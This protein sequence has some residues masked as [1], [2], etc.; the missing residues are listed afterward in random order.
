MSRLLASV[1]SAG[2]RT[3]A[4]TVSGS[5]AISTPNAAASVV[6]LLRSISAS[7]VERRETAAVAKTGWTL[8]SVDKE[9]PFRLD[10]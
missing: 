9:L 10:P 8:K 1:T 7:I 2:K 4:N 5:P 6:D 3:N